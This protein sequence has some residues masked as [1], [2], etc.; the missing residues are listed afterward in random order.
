MA[1]LEGKIAWVTGAG[2]GIGRA[3]ALAFAAEGARLALTGRRVDALKETAALIADPT[4]TL[5][6][7]ADVSRPVEVASAHRK[8]VATLGN[9]N[10][11]INNA[12]WNVGPRH[13]RDLTVAGL[14]DVVDIDLKG[15]FIC[16]LAVLPA[17]RARR[18]GTLI[19]IASLAAV[20]FNTISGP[21][22]TAAKQGVVGLSESLNA[23]EGINGIR[24]ICICPGEVET[25]LLDT[26]PSPPSP[27]ERALMAKPEDV[28]AAAL[29]CATLPRRACV[30]ML[31][32]V[33]TDNQA[34]RAGAERIAGMKRH[35]RQPPHEQRGDAP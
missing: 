32:L 19:H 27:A 30:T 16:S 26:R 6:L 4:Q 21:S 34:N 18:E 7:P 20:T 25:S 9:P 5:I 15:P 11:L 3:C 10:I 2:S 22:Y 14:S 33:P 12:G 28:A 24:S 29:F 31:V 13:W 1:S 23:E 17:M 35:A 8:L